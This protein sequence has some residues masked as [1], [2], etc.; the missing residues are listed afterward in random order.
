MS[1][2]GVLA[3]RKVATIHLLFLGKIHYY[4]RLD[5]VFL[6]KLYEFLIFP[7]SVV[8]FVISVVWKKKLN[9]DRT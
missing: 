9:D 4:N 8:F 7:V 2:I 3:L 6:Q 1:L 5:T